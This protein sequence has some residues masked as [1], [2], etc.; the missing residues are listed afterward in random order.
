MPA[1]YRR[2]QPF[3]PPD[4]GP[5]SRAGPGEPTAIILVM[6]RSTLVAPSLAAATL[7][8]VLAGVVGPPT[9]A[10]TGPDARPAPGVNIEQAASPTATPQF[11]VDVNLVTIDVIPRETDSDRFVAD[12]QKGDFDVL[13]DGVK[14]DVSSLVLVH[15][16]RTYNVA[17]PPP[18]AAIEG[19]ILPTSR[20]AR[21]EAGRIF[22]ILVDDLHLEPTNSHHV[23]QLIK[24]ISSTLLHEGDMV[25]MISTGPS[26]I[27]IEMTYDRKR[28]DG[29][30]GKIVGHGMTATDIIQ[31]AESLDGPATLRYRAHTAFWTVY[32]MLGQLEQIRN[33]RKAVL[34]VSQGA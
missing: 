3:A 8:S 5:P 9:H 21:D 20:A 11:K 1:F 7:G 13:E 31:G 15:G 12:L 18:A 22:M 34:Y 32:E 27:E 14:Q 29:A 33:R 10:S 24:K 23:R 25:A 19:I 30:V 16:G 17:L 4:E 6:P 2:L 28:V 26:A